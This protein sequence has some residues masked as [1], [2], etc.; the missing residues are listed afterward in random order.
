LLHLVT[1][2]EN[3]LVVAENT[4]RKLA[5][6]VNWGTKQQ[7]STATLEVTLYES[8]SRSGNKLSAPVLSNVKELPIVSFLAIL[9]GS[10]ICAAL[11]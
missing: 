3:F 11:Y 9:N 2:A 10:S 6:I 4:S 7:A 5:S 8:A 1:Q